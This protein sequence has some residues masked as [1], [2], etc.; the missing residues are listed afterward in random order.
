M[1]PSILIVEDEKN[2]REGLKTGL[3]SRYDVQLAEDANVA[4][5]KLSKDNIDLVLTDLRMPGM[6]GLE[7]LNKIHERSPDLPVILLTAYGSIETAVDAMKQGA[8]DYVSKPVNLDELELLI[9]RALCQLNLAKENA[10][11]KSQIKPGVKFADMIGT[12]PLMHEV[13]EKIQQVASSKI[14][15]LI[16]GKSGTGKELVARAIHTCGCRK[17]NPFIAVN[18]AALSESLLESEIFG[19]EKGSFTGAVDQKKGRFE[20]ADGGTIFLDEIT[21]IDP[22][23]QVK[24]L[25]ILEESTFE[26]VGGVKTLHVDVRVICATNVELKKAVDHGQF[27]E[28]LYYRIHGMKILLPDL[29]DRREDIPILAHLFLE[30]YSKTRSR[31]E[32]VFSK[33]VAEVFLKYTWPG[34]VRELRNCVESM[35][36]LTKTNEIK[37]HCLPEHIR[38]ALDLD[39]QQAADFPSTY[40]LG[41]IEKHMIEKALNETK[42]NRTKAAKLLGLSRRT[43]HRKLHEY[44]IS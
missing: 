8:Y 39:E 29:K 38:D 13:F 30:E 1:K 4:L 44:G 3:G 27:R 9:E 35:V 23:I 19:H 21:E 5:Q 15:I 32:L 36:L 26:R 12:S 42:N 22:R 41:K 7:L 28:D 17:D 18:C 6:D 31:K 14:S 16:E 33:D 43:L 34:N 24:L 40:N 25:R 10:Y 37:M 2:T 20:L 11:L